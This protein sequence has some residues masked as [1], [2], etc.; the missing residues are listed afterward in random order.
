MSYTELKI[1]ANELYKEIFT[2]EL[3]YLGFDTFET[4]GAFLLA[5][6]EAKTVNKSEVTQM[7]TRYQD[8]A[9]FKYTFSEVE[10]QN[11]NTEWEKNFQPIFVEDRVAVKATFHELDSAYPYEITITPKM[12]FGTGHHATTHIMLAYLLEEE[13]KGKTLVDLGCGTGIL[14]IMASKKGAIKIESCDIDDWCI[15]NSEEN[16]SLNNIDTINVKLGDV[17][18]C[19]SGCNFDVVLANINKNVLIKEMETYSAITNADGH[20]FLSG[21]YENDI[22]DLISKAETFGFKFVSSKVKD[23]WASLKLHKQN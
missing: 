1:E 14:A 13:L 8:S 19:F 15:E 16:F 7:L 12:S 17:A 2:A 11:W 22:N 4:E 6:G 20:L 21:F 18:S 3:S 5:Y 10:K 23:N 9:E